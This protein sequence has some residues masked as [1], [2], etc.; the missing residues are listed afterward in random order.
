[1]AGKKFALPDWL[2]VIITVP[3]P[4]ILIALAPD[5]LAGPDLT[6]TMTGR[7]DEAVGR[8]FGSAMM[9]L[10]TNAWLEMVVNGVIVLLALATISSCMT[11]FAAL[12]FELP[13]WYALMV[14]VP[15]PTIVTILLA[16]VATFAADEE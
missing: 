4:V 11:G 1:M 7:P 15:A 12:Q 8:G 6:L 16:M 14:V 10:D 9:A 3:P 5:I 13:G 2:A